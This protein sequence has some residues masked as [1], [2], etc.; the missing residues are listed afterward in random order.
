[1]CIEYTQSDISNNRQ[2]YYFQS[3]VILQICNVT[4][5]VWPGVKNDINIYK[6]YVEL[7]MVIHTYN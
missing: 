1:M 5:I 7:L 6:Y 4:R 2:L 3:K